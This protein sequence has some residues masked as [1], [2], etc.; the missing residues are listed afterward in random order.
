MS[1]NM[2]SIDLN[3]DKSNLSSNR[4]VSDKNILIDSNRR[5]S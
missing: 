2:G 3:A 4:V 5:N 1:L